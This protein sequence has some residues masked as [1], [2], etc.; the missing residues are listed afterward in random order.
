MI[1]EQE[2]K[3]KVDIL[4]YSEIILE[5][6]KENKKIKRKKVKEIENNLRKLSYDIWLNSPKINNDPL[7]QKEIISNGIQL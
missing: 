6:L 5:E 7:K 2:Y 1:S 3:E 4:W